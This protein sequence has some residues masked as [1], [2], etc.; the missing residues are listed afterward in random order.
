MAPLS[1]RSTTCG[2]LPGHC[3]DLDEEHVL[4]KKNGAFPTGTT[5]SRLAFTGSR[6]SEEL[7]ARPPAGNHPGAGVSKQL[8]NRSIFFEGDVDLLP[9]AMA[10]EG[11]LLRLEAAPALEGKW[12]AVAAPFSRPS[13]RAEL[14]EKE[15][16]RALKSSAS[17]RLVERWLS[18]GSAASVAPS[19]ISGVPS[20]PPSQSSVFGHELRN[21]LRRGPG[22]E[23]EDDW[24]SGRGEGSAHAQRRGGQVRFR[25]GSSALSTPSR[26]HSA[27][28]PVPYDRPGRRRLPTPRLASIPTTPSPI[29]AGISTEAMSFCLDQQQHIAQVLT[30]PVGN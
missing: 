9:G 7:M 13:G 12:S 27:R 25:C 5:T 17:N 29:A 6:Q 22:H 16:R 15:E 1:A 30:R 20:A 23:D 14:A 4:F 28:D 18:A 21:Y 24:F 3:T 26:A 19:A 11:H 2:A 10:A 8:S